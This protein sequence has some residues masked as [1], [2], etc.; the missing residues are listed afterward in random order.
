MPPQP[1]EDWQAGPKDTILVPGFGTVRFIGQ[2]TDF[3]NDP[4]DGIA[5]AAYMY[6]C[7]MLRHEDNGMMG[8]FIVVAPGQ[9]TNPSDYHLGSGHGHGSHGG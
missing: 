6:H 1:P 8:Q 3:A 9:S 2:F 4:Q 5:D 7:H